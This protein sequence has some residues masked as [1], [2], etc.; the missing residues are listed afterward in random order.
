MS[1]PELLDRACATH[2]STPSEID[3]LLR[4]VEHEFAELGH[5]Q[6]KCDLF[7][8]GFRPLC[9]MREYLKLR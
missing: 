6:F 2:A 4:A 3:E 9:V 8:L 1:E 5:R 7:A